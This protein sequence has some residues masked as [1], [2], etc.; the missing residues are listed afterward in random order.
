MRSVPIGT[1]APLQDPLG[2][3]STEASLARFRESEVIHGRWAMLGVAG[4]L[5]VE[6]LQLGNWFDAPLWVRWP[7]PFLV[8]DGSQPLPHASS[9]GI[10]RCHLGSSLP[11]L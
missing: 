11:V 3:G 10:V 6:I 5:A 2:L 4:A 9:R 7:P 8:W 1:V